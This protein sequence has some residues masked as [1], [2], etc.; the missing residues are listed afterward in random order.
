MRAEEEV[1]EK[2]EEEGT[3]VVEDQEDH[4]EDEIIR[5]H[6]MGEEEDEDLLQIGSV[7]S[8]TLIKVAIRERIVTSSMYLKQSNQYLKKIPAKKNQ[9]KNKKLLNQ[10]KM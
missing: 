7:L 10:T 2:A 9:K 6:Q 1:E 3:E 4:Q 5:V 8:L